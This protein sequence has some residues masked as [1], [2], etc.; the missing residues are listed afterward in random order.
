MLFQTLRQ[1]SR[2]AVFTDKEL[3]FLVVEGKEVSMHSGAI[4]FREGDPAEGVY[5]LLEGELEIT[6]RVA[7]QEVVLETLQPS[8]FVGEISVLGGGSPN[9]TTVRVIQDSRLLQFETRLFREALDT[10]PGWSILLSTLAQRLR[11]LEALVQQQEKLMALGKLAA[12]LAHELNNPAAAAQRA[13]L[14]MG[15]ALRNLHALAWKLCHLHLDTDQL[16]V[17]QQ[18]QETLRAHAAQ[19]PALDPLLQSDREEQLAAWIET[20]GIPDGW[21]LAPVLVS[22]GLDTGQ[23]EALEARVGAS[24][25]GDVLAWLGEAVGMSR[26]VRLVDQSTTRIFDLVQAIKAYSYM[27]QAPLQEIDIHEGLENTLLLLGYKLT[28]ITVTREYDRSLPRLRAYGGELNQVWTNLID[29]AIVAMGGRGQLWIRTAREQNQVRVEVAD[30]GPGIPPEIQ[31]RIFEPFFTTK[32]VGAG[33]GLG[34]DIVFHTI[35]ER[36]H[37]TIRVVS[38]PGDTRFQVRLPIGQSW[39]EGTKSD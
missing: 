15:E 33:T 10:M 12:G 32:P 20:R 24:A 14:H 25:L 23:V 3:Q 34:L 31:A 28:D 1:F 9:P 16:E 39:A 17:L 36:H 8:S 21:K 35:V 30:N 38:R 22:A 27:D 18:F 26:L 29:N 13:A 2:F 6:K 5:V 7:G 11:N 4:L 37:G 19:P